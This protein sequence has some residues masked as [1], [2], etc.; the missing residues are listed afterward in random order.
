MSTPALPAPPETALGHLHDRPRAVL[1]APRE[2][3]IPV[4]CRYEVELRPQVPMRGPYW[5]GFTNAEHLSLENLVFGY[6]CAFGAHGSVPGA[7]FDLKCPDKLIPIAGAPVGVGSA[8]RI[9]LLNRSD[10]SLVV[11]LALW[12]NDQHSIEADRLDGG[13]L[14]R[15]HDGEWR[16]RFVALEAAHDALTDQHA[17]LTA[18]LERERESA[19]PAAD[20]ACADYNARSRADFKATRERLLPFEPGDVWA[21]PTDES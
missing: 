4:G 12:G 14:Q 6:M 7:F 10:K 11:E 8:V 19:L 13:A 1:P 5:L 9:V 3:V 16:A 17:A 20:P 15:Q 21:T 18:E 2:I